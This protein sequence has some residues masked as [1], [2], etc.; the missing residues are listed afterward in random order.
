VATNDVLSDRQV[1]THC[2]HS[3]SRHSITGSARPD[4][5]PQQVAAIQACQKGRIMENVA[6][7]G[8]FLGMQ[9]QL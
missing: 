9:I 1:T 3:A 2:G 5:R 6:E 7:A 4:T 8:R